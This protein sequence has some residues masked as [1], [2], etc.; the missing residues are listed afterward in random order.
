M[1]WKTKTS[2]STR[3]FKSVTRRIAVSQLKPGD[4]LLKK[5][6]HIRLFYGWL[7]EAHTQYVAYEAGDSLVG[8]CRVHSIAEDLRA[9]YVPSRY[10]RITD[11]PPSA[12]LLQNGSF[13]SWARTWGGRGNQPVWWQTD[14]PW[15]Q[16][17]A[18]Q[19]RD[20]YRTSRSSLLLGNP[21]Q[22]ADE[23]TELSQSVRVMAGVNYRLTAWA[24]TTYDP[25]GLELGL[26][27][28]DAA[29]KSVAEVHSTGDQWGVNG[30]SF[31]PMAIQLVAPADAVRAVV[32][33]RLAGATTVDAGGSP[34]AGSS[35]TLDDLS[36][37]R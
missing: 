19:R 26:E 25:R 22:D 16:S 18:T 1:C 24:M 5:G 8:V 29:G 12:N 37:V 11:S 10:R 4:A 9:G 3:S 31:K 6:Y 35:V 2:Y 28:L 33:V 15:W 36:L 30:G 7:D 32:T 17:L 34:V 23:Y 14:G 27:Y 20:T 21:S 13:N